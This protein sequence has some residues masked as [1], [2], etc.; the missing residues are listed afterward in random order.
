MTQGFS[1]VGKVTSYERTAGGLPGRGVFWGNCPKLTLSHT[2]NVVERNSSMSVE[3]G[4]L[5]RMTQSTAAAIEVVCDEFNKANVSRS[6][7]ARVDDVAAQT[8][9]TYTCPVS[10]VA[11]GD[12]LKLPHRNISNLVVKD[13]TS[14][15]AKTLPVTAYELDSFDGSIVIKSLVPTG[16]GTITQPLKFEYDKGAVTVMA[17]LA[18]PETEIWLGM[19]GV[20]ADTGEPGVLDV[21]RVRFAVA[22]VMDF[23]NAEYQ[24]FT[25]KGT[26]LQDTTRT[27]E[28][29]GGKYY[30]F[31]LPEDHE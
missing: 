4:P 7:L 28:T 31:T 3:R 14:G 25:L 6:L 21:F 9:Q 12:S 27:T 30:Q 26:V 2:P 15:T 17:G 5:R 24:D 23:I 16:G 20:N 22:D 10:D 19:S 1:G 13:S 18:L 8:A 29:V 11:I